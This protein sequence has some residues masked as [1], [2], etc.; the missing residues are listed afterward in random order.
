M[1]FSA[2]GLRKGDHI[3]DPRTGEAVRGRRAAW[4]ALARPK[5]VGPEGNGLRLAAAAVAD[6]LTTALMLM[7]L[8]D[9]EALCEVSPGLEAWILV[10]P[11][12]G[13][14]ANTDLLHFGGA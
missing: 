3:R 6:A 1:A 11:A 7:R 10:D 12:A 5:P 13:T 9:I 2:S 8:E 4:A 14:T